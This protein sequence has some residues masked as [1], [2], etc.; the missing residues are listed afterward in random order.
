MSYRMTSMA[1][2]VVRIPDDLLQGCGCNEAFP[3]GVSRLF[4]PALKSKNILD[5][6]CITRCQYIEA[7][8]GTLCDA[9]LDLLRV[10]TRW[11]SVM[12]SVHE[13]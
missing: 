5:T 11:V 12:C 1:Y 2:Q 7:L 8:S 9:C 6:I 13:V 3:K 10:V 4:R